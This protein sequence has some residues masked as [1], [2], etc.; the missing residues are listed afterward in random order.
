MFWIWFDFVL[1]YL[2]VFCHVF[3]YYI[4]EK[5]DYKIKEYEQFLRNKKKN[6]N[7]NVSFL[8]FIAT[9]RTRFYVVVN[10]KKISWLKTSKKRF[11]FSL[12]L[13]LLQSLIKLN[14]IFL[15]IIF[16]SMLLEMKSMLF[17]VTRTIRFSCFWGA[18]ARN[19][20]KV[21]LKILGNSTF[22]SKNTEKYWLQETGQQKSNDDEEK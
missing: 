22:R 10:K 5:F 18:V 1:I 6:K 8:F 11:F 15:T 14:H 7:T 2:L 16:I 13:T 9:N 20:W 21:W 12:H 17:L 3:N 4:I 19:K